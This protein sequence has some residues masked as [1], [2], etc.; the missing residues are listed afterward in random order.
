MKAKNF[1]PPT[2]QPESAFQVRWPQRRSSV[3]VWGA[4]EEQEWRQ[5]EESNASSENY[6][7]HFW[8]VFFL[9][10]FEKLIFFLS[11]VNQD[12]HWTVDE[13]REQRSPTGPNALLTKSLSSEVGHFSNLYYR[14]R[15]SPL[16][17]RLRR[18]SSAASASVPGW[19][20]G[21]HISSTRHT[22]TH[23]TQWSTWT[24]DRLMGRYYKKQSP[25][26]SSEN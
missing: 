14:R 2:F 13:E 25:A 23:S 20:R 5:E 8:C 11:P 9:L 26:R 1:Q 19:T 17:E 16:S 3:E 18:S 10:F 6:F 7:S 12:P 21:S 24:V 15:F 22:P 4:A